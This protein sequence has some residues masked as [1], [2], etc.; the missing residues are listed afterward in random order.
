MA[1]TFETPGFPSKGCHAADLNR[2]QNLLTLAG[3]DPTNLGS[4]AEHI[5]TRLGRLVLCVFKSV[6]LHVTS[7]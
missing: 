1:C 7:Q 6:E 4:S 5:I 2:L 3:F